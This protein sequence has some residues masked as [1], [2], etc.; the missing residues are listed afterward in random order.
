ML[1]RKGN[2]L[3]ILFIRFLEV[4][5]L[6]LFLFFCLKFKVFDNSFIFFVSFVFFEIESEELEY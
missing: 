6:I 5:L 4:F 1:K 3:V 2:F